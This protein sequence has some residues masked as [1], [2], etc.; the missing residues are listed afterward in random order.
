MSIIERTS[1]LNLT[2]F[3]GSSIKP[4]LLEYY[5]S[6]MKKIDDGIIV[7]DG[8][9]DAYDTRLD[10]IEL[11]IETVSTANVDHL[12][13]R[14]DALEQKVETNSEQIT[15]FL[16]DVEMLDGR[17]DSLEDTY[18]QYGSRITTLENKVTR[19]EECY[20][21]VKDDLS[22]IHTTIGVHAELLEGLRT[23]VNKNRH[24]I[25]ANAQDITI[26]ATQCETNAENINKIFDDIPVEDI[27]ALAELNTTTLTAKGLT[28]SFA[29]RGGWCNV[30]ISGETTATIEDEETWVEEAPE[31]YIPAQDAYSHAVQPW[32]VANS[33]F[34]IKIGTDGTISSVVNGDDIPIGT[35]V[36]MDV[37][38]PVAISE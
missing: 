6:D 25:E 19:L 1:K 30:L 13:E 9:L 26:I 18:T 2:Q 21:D 8:I 10:A 20:A 23:D 3:K 35:V 12:T 37:N 27:I 15:H 32:D 38:Y 24:D 29:M 22:T 11:V 14:V 5:T 16:E 31:G 28:F 7:I 36:N 4:A 34:G 33:R 17:I